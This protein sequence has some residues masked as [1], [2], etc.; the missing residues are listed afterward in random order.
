MNYYNKLFGTREKLRE[1]IKRNPQSLHWY[2]KQ[3][4]IGWH[5]LHHFLIEDRHSQPAI[6][7]K[8]VNYLKSQ[9]VE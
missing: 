4:G 3:I 9:G 2:A 5:T 8:V 7:G 6:W 1:Y